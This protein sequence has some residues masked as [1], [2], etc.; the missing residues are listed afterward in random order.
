MAGNALSADVVEPVK[1]MP[2]RGLRAR[3]V[4]ASLHP[5]RSESPPVQVPPSL[6]QS[7]PRRASRLAGNLNI[8]PPARSAKSGERQRRKTRGKDK[9]Q[10]GPHGGVSKSASGQPALLNSP[11]GNTRSGAASAAAAI[12]FG[13]EGNYVWTGNIV[14]LIGF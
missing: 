3:D 9:S 12:A 2:I 7:S 6:E 1:R 5:N 13:L 10:L 11:A 4:V 14:S 8:L